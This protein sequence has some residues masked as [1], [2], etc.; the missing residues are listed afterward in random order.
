LWQDFRAEVASGSASSRQ[1]DQALANGVD[2]QFRGAMDVER[3]HQ[4]GTMHRDGVDAQLK[5]GGD[6]FVR[7]ALR[8]ELQN[9]LFPLREE[10]KAVGGL[11]VAG[12]EPARIA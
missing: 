10:L 2:Y 7:I 12:L 3:V 5:H 9:L 11:T 6:L 1:R 8:D 4:V